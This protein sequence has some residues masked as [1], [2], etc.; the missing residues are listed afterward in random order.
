[1][2]LL[3]RIFSIGSKKGKKSRQQQFANPDIQTAAV[4]EQEHEAVVGRLL[5]SSSSRY[6]VV[7]EVDYSS[8]PPLPH[9]INHVIPTPAASTVSLTS[10][11]PSQR[12]TYTVKVLER[13]QD[14]LTEFP[15][16][17]RHL[18]EETATTPPRQSKS[19]KTDSLAESPILRLRSDPSV[20]SLLEL[21]DE[22]G[23]LPNQAF[24]NSPPPTAW[25]KER[26]QRRRTG[27][28]LR[29]LLG[30][31]PSLKSRN[32]NDPTSMGDISW[33]ERFLGETES[34]VSSSS[35]DPPSPRT[36]TATL[37]HRPHDITISTD[38]N[39]SI[40]ALENPAISSMTVELSLTSEHTN[41][42]IPSTSTL[43]A[44][45]PQSAAEVFDF[46]TERRRSQ[47]SGLH[48]RYDTN[49]ESLSRFS[50]D[51]SFEFV[52]PNTLSDFGYIQDD[53]YTSEGEAQDATLKSRPSQ[54]PLPARILTRSST[55]DNYLTRRPE[56]RAHMP[57]S[58]YH[59]NGNDVMV[60]MT[61]PTTVIVTAPTPSSTRNA[62]SPA[63]RQRS[64][65]TK[66][67][68]PPRS[69]GY[70]STPKARRH[71][72][73]NNT[74]PNN[75]YRGHRSQHKSSPKRSNSTSLVDSN[76]MRPAERQHT[77][78]KRS[79]T[80][81]KLY[82]CDKENSL[83]TVRP[84]LTSTPIRS[85]STS[86]LLHRSALN[87]EAYRIPASTS[88]LDLS[89]LAQELMRL[90][91]QRTHDDEQGRRNTSAIPRRTV[92]I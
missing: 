47:R 80:L 21:Y 52:P 58:S 32:G 56:D 48:S 39:H 79:N 55:D 60:L 4:E 51:N 36:P 34:M 26:P 77:R 30:N 89:P 65:Q 76:V 42:E 78:Q 59:T 57:V 68:S 87:M 2:G 54:I 63:R 6:A 69:I 33:A 1:M 66:K 75:Q 13:K 18:D 92:R 45:T 46:L 67:G 85:S 3:K 64:S 11:A 72:S 88:S 8:L 90:A 17:N 38:H 70:R 84:E 28:T 22:H 91:R 19:S 23:R 10:T 61:D 14:A 86:R 29:Q 24:S 27:S 35:I 50:S 62:V 25:K 49:H 82:E 40:S 53:A 74:I 71:P 9:P 41:T 83:L 43:R 44:K 12:G 31:P 81:T 20:V 16:A 7:A 73:S 5:R 37:S 15:H